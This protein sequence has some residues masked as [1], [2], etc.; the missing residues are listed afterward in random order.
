MIMAAHIVM[1]ENAKDLES[2]LAR[3]NPAFILT[4][5]QASFIHSI[6]QNS[7]Q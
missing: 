3:Q 7:L 2:L 5:S 4:G 1:G 6:S